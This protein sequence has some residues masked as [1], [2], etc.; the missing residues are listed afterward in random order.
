VFLSLGIIAV[1]LTG[2]GAL[3]DFGMEASVAL[4]LTQLV[5]RVGKGVVRRNRPAAG[6]S[7]PLVAVPSCSSF[8]SAHAAWSMALAATIALAAPP[9]GVIALGV[10]LL[11]G[12][13][14]VRLGVHYPSDVIGGQLIGAAVSILVH[15]A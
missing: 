5:V 8:P 4:I 14:R 3:R 6:D 11:T 1:A 9:A 12:V 10:A 15:V 2:A 7:G 13:S